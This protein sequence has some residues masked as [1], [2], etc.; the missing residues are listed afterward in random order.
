MKKRC[1]GI[2]PAYKQPVL[3][4]CNVKKVRLS[5][6]IPHG[7][8]AGML[9]S[10]GASFLIVAGKIESEIAELESYEERQNVLEELGWKNRR[11][12]TY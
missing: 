2:I 7:R 9:Q 8:I 1:Q 6:E 12:E 10:E 4:V 3:Y 11:I 5:T